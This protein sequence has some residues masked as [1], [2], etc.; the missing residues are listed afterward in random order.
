VQN[1]K[2]LAYFQQY[3]GIFQTKSHIFNIHNIRDVLVYSKNRL[4]IMLK[5]EFEK[6]IIVSRDKVNLFKYRF[7]GQE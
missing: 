4:R 7:G 2:I 3:R 1:S 6:E 5:T